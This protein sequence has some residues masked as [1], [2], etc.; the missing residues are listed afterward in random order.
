MEI[1]LP[2]NQGNTFDLDNRNGAAKADARA[3]CV[4]CGRHAENS[5]VTS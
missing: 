5:R 4:T 3:V 2:G 1:G